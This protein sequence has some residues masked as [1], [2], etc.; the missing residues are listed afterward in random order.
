MK[1]YLTYTQDDPLS[2][3]D[4]HVGR[5][6]LEDAIL[7]RLVK[8]NRTVV[9]VTHYLQALTHAQQVGLKNYVLVN[10]MR[11][12]NKISPYILSFCFIA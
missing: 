9:M 6:V 5:Q 2:A 4:S 12:K 1:I 8:R 10:Q 7:R 11:V 3:L